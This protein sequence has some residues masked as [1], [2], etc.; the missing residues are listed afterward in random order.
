MAIPTE[1]DRQLGEI[2]DLAAV[3]MIRLRTLQ[4]AGSRADPES[5][6]APLDSYVRAV[7]SLAGIDE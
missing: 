1:Y 2:D 6:R 5:V 7:R 4:R 3:V